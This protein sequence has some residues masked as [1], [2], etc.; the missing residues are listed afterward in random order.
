[1]L[2]G[3]FGE[4]GFGGLGWLWGVGESREFDLKDETTDGD[5]TV[6][7]EYFFELMV[8]DLV[9]EDHIGVGLVGCGFG[10]W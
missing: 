6:W 9:G 3:E 10:W 1:M 4:W 2:V 8:F 7:S 5:G